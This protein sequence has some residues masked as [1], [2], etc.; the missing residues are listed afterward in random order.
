LFLIFLDTTDRSKELATAL[1][2][3]P[4]LKEIVLF[5][6][7]RQSGWTFLA[8]LVDADSTVVSVVLEDLDLPEAWSGAQA[9]KIISSCKWSELVIQNS[10]RNNSFKREDVNPFYDNLVT[11]LSSNKT[12]TRFSLK[13]I[14]G[15]SNGDVSRLVDGLRKNNSITHL[16]MALEDVWDRMKIKSLADFIRTSPQIEELNISGVDKTIF[17]INDWI[18]ALETSSLKRLIVTPLDVYTAGKKTSKGLLI[19]K[20]LEDKLKAIC[21]KN[22]HLVIVGMRESAIPKELVIS[23]TPQ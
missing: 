15:A 7:R 4:T 14:P 8:G 5:D 22:G 23:P 1:T 11:G 20:Y 3:K 9:V 6:P 21:D 2:E 19:D 10:K 18:Q 12:I 16:A 17:D 13:N